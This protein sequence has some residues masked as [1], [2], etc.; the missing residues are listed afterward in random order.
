MTNQRKLAFW[1]VLVVLV[2]SGLMLVAAQTTRTQTTGPAAQS[3]PSAEPAAPADPNAVVFRLGDEEITAAEFEPR[4]N[5]ALRG[6]AAQQGA[7][8]DAAT[9]EQFS[10]LRPNFLDQFATQQ[11]LL[12]EA[13]TRGVN[14][15][16][17]DV[18]A[19]LTQ[20]REGAGENFE[21]ALQQAGYEDE[22]ALRTSIQESLILQGVV[23][24]L[25]G[26]VTVS[27]DS[28]RQFYDQNQAQF[29]TPEQVCARHILLEEEARAA[30]L[31]IQ[32]Q[33]GGNFAEIARNNSTD[34]GSGQQGGDLGC[35]GR[36]QMV[37]PFEEAAFGAEVG[38]TVGP[39]QSDF[40]YHIIRVYERNPAVTTPF[41]EV[42]EQV[43]DQLVDQQLGTRIT[44]LREASGAELFPENLPTTAPT[45]PEQPAA[46]EPAQP[47]AP[48]AP[49]T[50][51]AAPET[52]P[53]G[54]TEGESEGE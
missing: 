54:E 29:G 49:S 24:Q 27:P 48:A 10:A 30:E 25:R 17:A 38:D 7:P 34:T 14:V 11:V 32:L 20:A 44:A 5:V 4:F 15:P 47:A 1:T 22:A 40:G 46:A 50:E 9:L 8:L 13:D 51:P 12:Q 39:V 6:L 53:E 3:A 45:A 43:R 33:D 42:R 37:P 52:T 19:Q 16:E 26:E 23:E 31:F 28:V 35:F 21:Q 36:G 41:P 2:V 18:E